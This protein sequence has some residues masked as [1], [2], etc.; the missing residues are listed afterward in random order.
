MTDTEREPGMP[1]PVPF[2]RIEQVSKRFGVVQALRDVSLEVR[3]GEVLALVGETGAGSIRLGDR[4]VD[5][6]SPRVAHAAGIRV[7]HQEP[8]IIPELTVA[9]N[10]FIGDFRTQGGVFL[11]QKDLFGRTEALLG[12]FGMADVLRPDE[13]CRGLGPAQ[14]QLIEIMRALRPGVKLLAFDEPTSSLTDDESGRLFAMIRRLKAD[15]VGII[16]ISHRLPEVMMLADRVA[17]L[18]DGALV[19]VE[20]ASGLTEEDM[21]RMMVGRPVQDLFG[22]VERQPGAVRLSV[23]GLSSPH[24][25]DISLSVRAGEILGIGGLVGAGRSE[26]ARALV[27]ADPVFSG[28]VEIDGKPVRIVEPADAIQAG[29]GLVPEDRKQEALLLTQSVRNNASLVV[30]D[31][32]SSFGIYSSGRERTLVSGLVDK[33]RVKTPSIEQAVGKLS[34]GN[35][36]K[37]VFARWMAREPKILIL[38]EPT[39][40]IDVGSKAEIYLLIENLARDGMAIILISSEMPELLGLSDRVLVMAGG[41]ITG[42]LA[43]DAATEEAVLDLAMRDQG[44]RAAAS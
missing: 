15:G 36:Q 42:E 29:I 3:T 7:I 16:Y 17:V 6:T 41:R 30:P 40:G 18:R 43:G 35:Q 9:E 24:V 31:K 2:L 12:A 21:V 26:L 25:K 5:F 11:D 19:G 22:R 44:A 39:R 20:S 32:I 34:G 13:R 4:A 8:E 23:R 28:A 14:R 1:E 27:G 37:V 38:D 33:L 10:I